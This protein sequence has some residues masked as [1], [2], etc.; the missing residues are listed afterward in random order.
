[1]SPAEPRLDPAQRGASPEH[2]R[3]ADPGRNSGAS[4]ALNF[5]PEQ[6]TCFLLCEA[7]SVGAVREAVRLAD[8]PFERIGEA[9]A[10]STGAL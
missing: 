3:G 9:I 8:L 5:R 1:M 2:G 4:I 10:D 6:E 7:E